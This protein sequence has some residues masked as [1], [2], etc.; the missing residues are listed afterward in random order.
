MGVGTA[1][2]LAGARAQAEQVYAGLGGAPD[3]AWLPQREGA[4]VVDVS[5]LVP[6]ALSLYLFDRPL[7]S[8][9][10]VQATVEHLAPARY[11]DGSFLGFKVIS[12]AAGR[13]RPS[14]EFSGSGDNAPGDY[15]NG[16]SW[17]LYDALAL[18]AAARRGIDRRADLFWQRLR[19]EVSRSWASH[20]FI[21]T[22]PRTPGYSQ[23]WRD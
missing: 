1:A 15:Q 22:N 3:G 6:E 13:Y 20:E 4:A 21:S 9:E 11:P 16:G 5:A 7:L 18:C 23:P 10:K 17:L 19:S 12:D 2:D 8:T 14:A